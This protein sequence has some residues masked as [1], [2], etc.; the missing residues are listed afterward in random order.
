VSASA[1]LA[2]RYGVEPWS[3]LES[4]DRDVPMKFPR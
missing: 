4:F 1:E 2:R 3:N